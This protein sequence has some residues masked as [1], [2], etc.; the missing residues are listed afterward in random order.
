MHRFIKKVLT[1]HFDPVFLPVQ[2]ARLGPVEIEAPAAFPRRSVYASQTT[3]E[4][5]R[6]KKEKLLVPLLVLAFVYSISTNCIHSRSGRN[7]HF[8][9]VHIIRR[10][11]SFLCYRNAPI[12]VH[13]VSIILFSFTKHQY[14]KLFIFIFW[15]HQRSQFAFIVL[16]FVF[17][18]CNSLRSL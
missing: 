18:L 16:F 10:M 6:A 8:D 2:D 4:L 5:R 17:L 7:R 12:F 14:S 11:Q 15:V 9:D 1:R 3:Y 13:F